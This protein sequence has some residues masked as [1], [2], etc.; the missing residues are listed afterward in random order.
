VLDA[1][2]EH[3][4]F[5]APSAP[6]ISTTPAR[7]GTPHSHSTSASH[8]APCNGLPKHEAPEPLDTLDT[9]DRHAHRD[10]THVHSQQGHQPPADHLRRSRTRALRSMHCAGYRVLV[11][12]SDVSVLVRFARRC[13]RQGGLTFASGSGLVIAHEC[14]PT[15]RTCKRPQTRR[16]ST[17][18]T[19]GLAVGMLIVNHVDYWR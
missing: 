19:I 14:N 8:R 10:I 11:Q 6:V 4:R 17:W 12:L 13:V 1:I 7:T 3:D 15:L 16:W 9:V 5:V 2:A 18:L